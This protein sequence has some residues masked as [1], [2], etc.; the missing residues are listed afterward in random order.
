MFLSENI[1]TVW[2]KLSLDRQRNL[3][4]NLQKSGHDSFFAHKSMLYVRY[5]NLLPEYKKSQLSKIKVIEKN[6]I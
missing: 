5:R 6:A 4:W 1:D 2:A 3:V